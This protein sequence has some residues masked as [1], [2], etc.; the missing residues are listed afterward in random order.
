MAKRKKQGEV[1]RLISSRDLTTLMKQCS[2]YQDKAATATGHMGELVREYAEH[3]NLHRGAFSIIKR[4]YRMGK[5]D[6]GKLW[7][8]LAHFDDYRAK[9]GLDRIA[10]EQGQLL[11]A[12]TEEEKKP[13]KRTYP[14]AV[15]ETL[16]P[17]S[18]A[19]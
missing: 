18:A 4:L 16:E 6:S 11:P 14:R 10:K 1:I 15:E 7:L 17:L 8:L 19:E 12:G 13:P 9:L 3:K 5:T 2:S